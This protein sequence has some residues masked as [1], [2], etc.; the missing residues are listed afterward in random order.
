MCF[1]I[2][3]CN[4]SIASGDSI[5]MLLSSLSLSSLCF[6]TVPSTFDLIRLKM[7]RRKVSKFTSRFSISADDMFLDTRLDFAIARMVRSGL[8]FRSFCISRRSFIPV[9]LSPNSTVTFLAFV[10]SGI[11]IA[12]ISFALRA[13]ALSS[14]V[15]SAISL[16]F[17]SLTALS[18]PIMAISIA[19]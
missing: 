17:F 8:S 2:N 10:I 9:T 5:V 18:M 7:A 3:A 13:A 11:S 14:L 1:I 16:F 6:L 12:G 15:C 19:R 4:L